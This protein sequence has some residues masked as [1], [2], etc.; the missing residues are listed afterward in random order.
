MTKLNAI[1]G[2]TA[3]ITPFQGCPGRASLFSAGGFPWK[4][5]NVSL[6]VQCYDLRCRPNKMEHTQ[7]RVVV[8]HRR[9]GRTN[10]STVVHHQARI[11]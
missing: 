1:L 5:V 8:E 11:P 4:V 9:L 10:S 3:G 6:D 2:R 7:V